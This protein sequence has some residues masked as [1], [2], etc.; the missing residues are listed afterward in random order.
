MSEILSTDLPSLE[1]SSM[2]R[3]ERAVAGPIVGHCPLSDGEAEIRCWKYLNPDPSAHYDFWMLLTVYS[4][5]QSGDTLLASHVSPLD[6][7]GLV[8]AVRHGSY[9]EI[10]ESTYI[11]TIE[12][13]HSSF[14]VVKPPTENVVGFPWWS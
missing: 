3:L 10:V 9:A 2:P 12:I 4:S 11:K 14:G 6:D 7:G 1:I 13:E 8:R 5:A